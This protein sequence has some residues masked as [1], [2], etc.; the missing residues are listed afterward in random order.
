M[1]LDKGDNPENLQVVFCSVLQRFLNLYWFGSCFRTLAVILV[2]ELYCCFFV[3]C[4][5]FV[6]LFVVFLL[7]GFVC[8]CCCFSEGEGGGVKS[9]VETCNHLY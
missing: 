8:C 2:S 3:F 1:Y 6:C 4:F 5:L 7:F 9:C